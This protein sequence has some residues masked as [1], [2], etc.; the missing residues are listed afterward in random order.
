MK[1]IRTVNLLWERKARGSYPASPYALADDGA[2]LRAAPRPNETRAYDMARVAPNET[3]QTGGFFSSE[4]LIKLDIADDAETAMGMTADD[5]YLFRGGGKAR[6]LGERQYNCL[7]AALDAGGQT[8]AVAF[9]D[10]AGTN[11]GLACG[12]I[13]GR[14]AWIRESETAIPAVAVSRDGKFIVYGLEDG[15]MVCLSAGT[16]EIWTFEQ[17]EPIRAVACSED[18]ASAVYGTID[19]AV[20]MID[21]SGAR[22]WEMRFPGEIAAVALSGDGGLCAVIVHPKDS[23]GGAKLACVTENGQIGW[24]YNTEKRLL[25]VS[26]SPNGRYVAAGSRDGTT[27]VYEIVPS[28]LTGGVIAATLQNKEELS[29]AAL[30]RSGDLMGAFHVLREA[31]NVA[32]ANVALSERAYNIRGQW[33]AN[34]HAELKSL[35]EAENWLAAIDAAEKALAKDPRNPATLIFLNGAMVGQAKSLLAQAQQSDSTAAESLLFQA[36]TYNPFLTEARRE[37]A[38]LHSRRAETA[39]AEAEQFAANGELEAAI[40]AWERAQSVLPTSERAKK[41]AQAQTAAEYAAGLTLYNEKRYEQA[42]FQFRKAL[43]RDPNH[44]DAKRYLNFAQ[45]FAQNSADEAQTDRFNFLE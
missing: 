43:A 23:V 28:E 41:I 11:F 30:E 21:G 29:A 39:D 17:A 1:A 3:A 37:L 8:L 16:S 19:G 13:S 42:I 9:C 20:G 35:S 6:F 7:D 4:T 10:V 31:M 45:K 40:S 34:Q 14:V 22:L 38:S 2:L 18:G 32:P 26:V 36:L 24:E 44:A 5:I 27:T 33:R 12:N 15:A 25:R